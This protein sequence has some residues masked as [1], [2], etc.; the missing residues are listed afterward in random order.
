MASI[1]SNSYLTLC[2]ADGV[3][4]ESG[5]LGIRQCSPPRNVQQE[6]L[7]FADGPIS[8]KWV[9]HA[10]SAVSVYDKRG[11]TFQEQVLSRRTLSFTGRGLLWRC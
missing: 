11:W 8:S 4:A 10:H 3:D 5:L 6:I 1:Y 2:A 7:V 9:T